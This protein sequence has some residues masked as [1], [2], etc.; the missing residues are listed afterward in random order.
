MSGC[1]DGAKMA[2][3]EVDVPDSY[4]GHLTHPTARKKCTPALVN[5]GSDIDFAVAG[6]ASQPS[7]PERET[8][9]SLGSSSAP[10]WRKATRDMRWSFVRRLNRDGRTGA[11]QTSRR[12]CG[13]PLEGRFPAKF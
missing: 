12:Q 4:S 1:Y 8:G 9:T 13:K 3:P 10:I 6:Q 2:K 7:E 5:K 11:T